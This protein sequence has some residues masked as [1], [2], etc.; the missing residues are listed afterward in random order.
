MLDLSLPKIQF[1]TSK[2]VELCAEYLKQTSYAENVSINEGVI[3][4]YVDYKFT[5]DNGPST[6]NVAWGQQGNVMWSW[7]NQYVSNDVKSRCQGPVTVNYTY[8][9]VKHMFK[10]TVVVP[11]SQK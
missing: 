4:F 7:V 9:Y 10:G 11:E 8:M 3:H 2:S 5:L 1:G 6:Y